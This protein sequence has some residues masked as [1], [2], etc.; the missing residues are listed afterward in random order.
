MDWEDWLR[1]AAKRPSNNEDAKRDRTESQ[2]RDALEDYAPLYAKRN[3]FRVYTKG[4]YAN[5]TN[6]RLDYDVDIAVEYYGYFYSDLVLD[7]EGH[8]KSEVNVVDSD[9]SYTRDEFKHD[10]LAALHQAFGKTAVNG[11]RI[12][13]RVREK[14]TTLPAD[15]VPCWEY[16]RYDRIGFLGNPVY[17]V[18]SRV[19]PSDGGHIEN[20]PKIQ[21]ERGTAKNNRTGRRYKRMVRALKKLQTKLVADGLLDEELPSYFTECLVFNVLDSKFNHWTYRSDMREV[22]A[23]IFNETLDSGKHAEWEEV[24]GLKYLFQGDFKRSKAHHMADVAWD[25]MGFN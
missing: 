1:T 11:G 18:G 14:K 25:A 6:V 22:L 17:H 4:S 16:R 15:V 12:A 10:V 24:H 13:Y 23:S 21:L 5:N 20:Y 8:D 7:L 3:K 9:D 19:Y 2:I